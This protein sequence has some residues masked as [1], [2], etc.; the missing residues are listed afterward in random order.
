MIAVDD[1]D[2]TVGDG[3]FFTL[4]GPSGSGKTTTLRM[5]AGFE[6]PDRGRVLLGGQDITRRPP[7]AR[8]VNTV[9]QDYALFPHMTVGENVGYG[10]KVKGVGR[11]E[12]AAQVTEVLK[13]VR[14]DGLRGPQAGAAL[15][16]PAAARRA[17]ALDRQPAEGAAP[18]RAARRAR[19]EAAPGDAGLP[20]SA[21]AGPRHDLPLRHA[22]PGGG[23][24]DERPRRRLQRGQDRAGRLSA[25]DLRAPGDRVRRRL[26]RHVEH[27]RARRPPLQRA[28]GADRARRQRRARDGRRR[29]VRRRVHP[30][31]RRHGRRRAAHGRAPE[32]RLEHR[33]RRTRPPL[34]AR[35]GR[36]RD[37]RTTPRTTPLEQEVR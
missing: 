14:L 16:R 4:L 37:R 22:R 3:E 9:F 2:V 10:L 1:V 36:V 27:P 6:Q 26:R 17:R 5:I 31:D 33:A 23:A 13:M 7:Y 20:E 8:D 12:R 34:V 32:R 24:D 18:R 28:A 30:R 19:P 11:R 29:R 25:R 21:P 35:R 15:G